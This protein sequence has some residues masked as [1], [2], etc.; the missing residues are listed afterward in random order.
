[1][2]D[3]PEEFTLT[4]PCPLVRASV[5]GEVPGLDARLTSASYACSDDD[6]DEIQGGAAGITPMAEWTKHRGVVNIDGVVGAAQVQLH[7]GV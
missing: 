7:R 3:V 1:M 6:L 5:S 4:W 2:D